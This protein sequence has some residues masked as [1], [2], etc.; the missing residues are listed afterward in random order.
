MISSGG[1][2]CKTVLYTRICNAQHA[3]RH[4]M[5]C[6]IQKDIFFST[7]QLIPAFVKYF[8]FSLASLECSILTFCI[9]DVYLSLLR[10]SD[11]LYPWLPPMRCL[12]PR[13]TLKPTS[14]WH[15]QSRYDRQKHDHHQV[16]GRVLREV[17]NLKTCGM[18]VSRVFHLLCSDHGCSWLNEAVGK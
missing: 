12:I 9:N 16:N 6:G 11:P 10:H 1:S 7:M 18:C 17:S 14:K 13:V 5:L 8:T 15:R 3:N 2:R 4:P